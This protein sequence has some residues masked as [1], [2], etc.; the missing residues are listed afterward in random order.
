MIKG[1]GSGRNSS[2]WSVDEHNFSRCEFSFCENLHIV[3]GNDFCLFWICCRVESSEYL[4]NFLRLSTL[5]VFQRTSSESTYIPLNVPGCGNKRSAAWEPAVPVRWCSGSREPVPV[6]LCVAYEKLFGHNRRVVIEC[7]QD[8]GVLALL[9][10]VLRGYGRQSFC[11]CYKLKP[12][13]VVAF[14]EKNQMW[15]DIVRL[16]L[17]YGCMW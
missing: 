7:Q 12:H 1:N 11:L 6:F 8:C 9:F 13:S 17:R 10:Q 5:A 4:F 2:R 15:S 14:R 3:F 16:D